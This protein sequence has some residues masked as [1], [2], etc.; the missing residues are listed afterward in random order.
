M[1][2]YF[3]SII[4]TTYLKCPYYPLFFIPLI[5][6]H[7]YF[8][9][10]LHSFTFSSILPLLVP[11]PQF[12]IPYSTILHSTI[13]FLFCIMQFHFPPTLFLSVSNKFLKVKLG[14]IS[15]LFYVILYLFVKLGRFK[16]LV[17][18]VLELV[19]E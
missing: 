10:L 9:S 16:F 4:A 11:V 14:F 3:H 5:H 2:P 17:G 6:S 13:L 1:N 12:N 7:M 19:S 15:C 8:S 18:L